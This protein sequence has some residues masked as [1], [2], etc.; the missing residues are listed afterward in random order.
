M[1]SGHRGAR[2][3]VF[4]GRTRQLTKAIFWTL[5]LKGPSLAY[6]ICRAVRAQKPFKYIKYPVVN[7]RVRTLEE[8]GYVE[9]VGTRKTKAGFEAA[10]Y[11]LTAKAYL[12]IMLNQVDLDDFIDEADETIALEA[13]AFFSQVF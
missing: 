5:A 3:S 2:V 12:A 11:Q 10:L 6:E 9:R 4:K 8:L 7:R 13:L 1:A